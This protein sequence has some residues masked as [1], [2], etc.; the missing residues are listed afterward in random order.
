MGTSFKR[1]AFDYLL[2]FFGTLFMA[3]ALNIFFE[4]NNIVIGGATGVAVI[5]KYLTR[6]IVDG[7]LSLGLLNLFI[8]VP[9]FLVAFKMLGVR[10]VGK[11]VVATLMLSFNLE[12]TSGCR[13]F[14]GDFII[15]SVFGGVLTGVGLALIFRARATTGGSDLAASLIH[16]KLKQYTISVIL[17]LIDVIIIGC[18]YFIFGFSS[19]MYAVISVFVTSKVIDAVLEG[20][21]FAK[22]TYIISDRYQE[23]CDTIFKELD[24]G[25]TA[26]Y[27]KGMY[28]GDDKNILL[29][30]VSQKEVFKLKEVAK[31]V[32]TNAFIMVADVREVLGDG[33]YSQ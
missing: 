25:V 24:R 8:N 31:K 33:F 12:L 28:S 7:G 27:G 3:L 21:S 15:I 18:G 2:I 10:F 20:V 17:L 32:D 29:C 26:I 16:H 4:P 19:T 30:I 5:I 6:N 1:S 22:A 9:L 11:T 14:Y 23:I 13:A